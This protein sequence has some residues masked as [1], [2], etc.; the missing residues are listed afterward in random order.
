[1]IKLI[2]K[3]RNKLKIS[4]PI[5]LKNGNYQYTIKVKDKETFK[6]F[7]DLFGNIKN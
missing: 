6:I 1:M 3:Y 4:E 2:E 5:Q 7:Y